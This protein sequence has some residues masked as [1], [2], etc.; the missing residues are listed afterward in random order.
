M[1]RGIDQVTGPRPCVV[2]AVCLT[3]GRRKKTTEGSK[4]Q[5]EST[6]EER[7]QK[8]EEESDFLM[9]LFPPSGPNFDQ[10]STAAVTKSN[11]FSDELEFV[12]RFWHTVPAD[13]LWCA[14]FS[15]NLK[16]RFGYVFAR[17]LRACS[18]SRPEMRP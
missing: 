14:S 11:M 18:H 4:K 16:A 15:G 9:K 17:L 12:R 2:K 10:K 7:R 13:A 3:L 1:Q 6:K 8:R 5:E